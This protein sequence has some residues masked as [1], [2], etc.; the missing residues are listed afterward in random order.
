MYHIRCRLSYVVG[1]E[2]NV[3][4]VLSMNVSAPGVWQYPRRQI[5]PLEQWIDEHPP[6][7][8]MLVRYDPARHTEVVT[9]DKLVGGPH[10]QGNIKLLEV[11]AVSF[12]IL[13]AIA[14]ITRLHRPGPV[15]ALP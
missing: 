11:C 3:T 5:G 14:R 1:D 13:L 12:V 10:T 15:D 7:T 6:G 8:P 2:Q 4:T 9:T